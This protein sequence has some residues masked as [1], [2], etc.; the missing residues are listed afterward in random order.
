MNTLN[1]LIRD[2]VTVE[3]AKT[4]SDKQDKGLWLEY[5]IDYGMNTAQ[6]HVIEHLLAILCHELGYPNE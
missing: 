5:E 3:N 4:Y 1:R 2:F 6:H